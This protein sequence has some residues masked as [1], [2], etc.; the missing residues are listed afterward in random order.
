MHHNSYVMTE[1]ARQRDSEIARGARGA[2]RR[3]RRDSNPKPS[4]PSAHGTVRS[5]G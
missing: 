2:G 3:A 4:D 5:P 1:L